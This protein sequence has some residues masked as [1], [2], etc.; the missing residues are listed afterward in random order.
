MNRRHDNW[1][2]VLMLWS[3]S[4]SALGGCGQSVTVEDA[5]VVTGLDAPSVDAYSLPTEDSGTDAP[6]TT[7]DAGVDAFVAADSGPPDAGPEPCTSEG[8]FRRVACACG[9]MQSERCMSGRWQVAVACDRET[10]CTPGAFE[11]REYGNCGMQQ[12]ECPDGCEWTEWDIVIPSGECNPAGT[13]TCYGPPTPEE[14]C[15]CLADCTCEGVPGCP[16]RVG[17]P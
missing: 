16:Y 15:H 7:V 14:N 13:D 9:G 12:R 11:T 6:S 5:A 3:M 8:M 2:Q 1:F 17:R 10:V 4:V